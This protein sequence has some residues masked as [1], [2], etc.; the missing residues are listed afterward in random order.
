MGAEPVQL[1]RDHQQLAGRPEPVDLPGGDLLVR[2]R[3]SA[4]AGG[5]EEVLERGQVVAARDA[6]RS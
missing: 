6:A 3:G 4:A 2:R 5:G 1:A